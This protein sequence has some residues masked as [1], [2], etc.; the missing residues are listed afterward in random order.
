MSTMRSPRPGRSAIGVGFIGVGAVAELHRRALG[1][2][3]GARLVAVCGPTDSDQERAAA[4][5]VRAYREPAELVA[6]P[7]VEVVFVLSPLECHVEH[8]LLALGAGRPV[9]VEKPVASSVQEIQ[10]LVAEAKATGL[11][12]MPAHNYIYDPTLGRARRMLE[13]GE[14]GQP[15]MTWIVYAIHHSEEL[16]SRY[17]GVLRQILPHHL[18]TLLY[19][20]GA[21]RRISAMRSHINSRRLDREDQVALQVEMADGSLAHLFATFA[22]D[23]PTSQPWTFLVKL[24]GTRGGFVH[25]WRDAVSARVLGTH[26]EAFIAYEESYRAEDEHFLTRCLR[27]EPP[28]STLEDAAAVQQ[29][30]EAAAE[31][32]A[33]GRTLDVGPTEERTTAGVS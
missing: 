9:L 27:G 10:M 20:Q 14:L 21:P 5:D 25:S 13:A 15:C 7:E 22:A 17:P 29:L 19:L 33:T 3:P 2:I 1:A 24:L 30:V 23:D 11:P 8:T 26:S 31:S 12:C 6:D 16:A 32:I 4:C 18:Y 28:L